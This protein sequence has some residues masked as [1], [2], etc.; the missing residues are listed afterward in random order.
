MVIPARMA[1]TRLPGKPIA[2]IAGEPM[3]VHC[4][5]RAIEA[6]VGPVIVA[7]AESEVARVIE[8]VGGVAVMTDPALQSGSDR[9]AAALKKVDPDEKHD[10]ILNL[11][12]DLPT[13]DPDSIRSVLSGF[14]RIEVDIVTLACQIT[15]KNEISNPN[16]VKAVISMESNTTVG[17][18]LYFSRASVPAG[19]GSYYHHIGIYA[20]R[21]AALFNFISLPVSNLEK[22]EKLEQLR[23]LEAGMN[24]EVVLVD[25]VP[26]GVDTPI[27]L[28]R[29]RVLLCSVVGN[30]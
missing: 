14:S 22:R 15:D 25:T 26:L 28:D 29:A 7:C 3:V 19:L 17:R 10:V 12:G 20:Y 24:I 23:A 9:V 21:R 8:A 6:D 16:V 5:R 4:W 2:D 1:S 27:D 30:C 13:L 11:Q 18:A